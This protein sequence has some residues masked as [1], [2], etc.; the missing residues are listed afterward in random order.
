MIIKQVVPR[1]TL[2]FTQA[3][4]YLRSVARPTPAPMSKPPQSLLITRA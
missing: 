3:T 2:R 4:F 1:V